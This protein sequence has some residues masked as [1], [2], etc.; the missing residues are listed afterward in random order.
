MQMTLPIYYTQNFKTKKDKTFMVGMNW[1]RNAHYILANDVKNR[2]H[3]MIARQLHGIN[4]RFS[5]PFMHYKLFYKTASSDMMNVVDCIDKFTMDALQE[6]G[7]IENDNVKFYQRA[8]IEVGGKDRENPRM[9][10][11]VMENDNRLIDYFVSL[12]S[13]NNQ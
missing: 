3:S 1:Y 2:Y 6:C 9:E 5:K 4:E 7:M 10:V 12:F 8:F 13:N 11:V